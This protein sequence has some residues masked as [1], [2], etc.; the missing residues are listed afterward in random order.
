M[1]S[2]PEKN[3]FQIIWLSASNQCSDIT[4]FLIPFLYGNNSDL[5]RYC[6]LKAAEWLL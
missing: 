4:G 6:D 3:L 5:E 1:Y 2:E